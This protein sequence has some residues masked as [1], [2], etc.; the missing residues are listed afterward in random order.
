MK[1]L[2]AYLFCFIFL[3]TACESEQGGTN[4]DTDKPDSLLVTNVADDSTVEPY[5]LLDND[6]AQVLEVELPAGRKLKPHESPRRIIFS[7][8]DYK[9]AWQTAGDEVKIE[10]WKKGQAHFHDGGTHAAENIGETEANWIVFAR[11]PEALLDCLEETKEQEPLDEIEGGFTDALVKNEH[12]EAYRVKLLPGEILP[13]HKANHRILY[14]LQ[15]L[16][17]Y[18][19][20]TGKEPTT[21]QLEKGKAKWFG[22]CPHMLQNKTD[23]A[24]E[25]LVV[26]YLSLSKD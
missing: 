2:S 9:L 5:T 17:L 23:E 24:V 26:Q 22:P 20:A 13:K 19:E 11:K 6:N 3:F 12:F 16:A 25:F 4:E 18:H 14:A 7:L 8:S 1:Q 10:E 21:M 15:D